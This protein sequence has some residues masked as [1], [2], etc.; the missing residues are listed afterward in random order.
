[1]VT[2]ETIIQ[3]LQQVPPEHL[4]KVHELVQTLLPTP[5]SNEAIAARLHEILTGPDDLSPEAWADVE[6]HM[7]RTRTELFTRPNPFMDEEA[8]P[9]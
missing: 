8:H 2:L 7:R 4:D 5:V 1:M 9:A 3:E 6:A